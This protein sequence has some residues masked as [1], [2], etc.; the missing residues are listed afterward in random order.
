MAKAAAPRA[1]HRTCRRKYVH[2]PPDEWRAWTDEADSTIISPS[3]HSRP[4]T[5]HTRAAREARPWP[6]RGGDV[7]RPPERPAWPERTTW[8]SRYISSRPPGRHLANPASFE[9]GPDGPGEVL[10]PVGVGPVLVERGAGGREQHDVAG[11]GQPGRRL[12]RLGHR[13]GPHDRP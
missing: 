1:S 9:V 2:A 13:P 11:L 3:R 8:W 12:H 5:M 10:A 4:T 7:S 6:K